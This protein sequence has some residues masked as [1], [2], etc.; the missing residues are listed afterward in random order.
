MHLQVLRQNVCT[1]DVGTAGSFS[2][3]GI[4]TFKLGTSVFFW[5]DLRLCPL[6][7][8]TPSTP[9]GRDRA[10]V[11]CRRYLSKRLT[12]QFH[13]EPRTMEQTELRAG[14]TLARSGLKGAFDGLDLG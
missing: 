11:E 4:A 7:K 2:N 14:S 3:E 12:R 8:S 6:K 9:C 10:C 5:T 1:V 13:P